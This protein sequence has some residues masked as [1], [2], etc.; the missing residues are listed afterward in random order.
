MNVELLR[1]YCL[2]KANVEEAFPFGD[3]NLVLKVNG[4]I[5][6]IIAL[7]TQ[8]L[9]FNAKCN[10]DEAI[11]LRAAYPTAVLPGYHMNKKHWNTIIVN[12]ILSSQ[13]LKKIIDNSYQLVQLKK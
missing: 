11:E 9:Q 4:K 7:D 1:E 2:T 3:T 5:F 12:G 10:P 6:L 13:Q 8:P